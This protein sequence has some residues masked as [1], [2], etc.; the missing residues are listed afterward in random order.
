VINMSLGSDYGGPA[1]DPDIVA[2]NNAAEAGVIVVIAAGN[3]GDNVYIHGSPGT[4]LKGIG[5][6]GVT[7]P[8]NDLFGMA[9]FTPT[10]STHE[11]MPADWGS[12]FVKNPVTATVAYVGRGCGGID[13]DGAVDP[14]L[15]DPVTDMI[16]LIDRGTCWFSDKAITAEDHGAAGVLIKTYAGRELSG[17]SPGLPTHTVDIPVVMIL[18]DLGEAMK[19]LLPTQTITVAL[20]GDYIIA[21]LGDTVYASSSRG[22]RYIDSA[23]KPDVAAPSVNVM[24]AQVGTGD[25]GI[26]YSGTS[27][28]TPHVAG[29]AALLR[30][31]F[32]DWN[33]WEIKAALMNTAVD[34]AD[35]DG[36]KY[37]LSRQGAGR[38]AVYEAGQ[39][40]SVALGD[41][42]P[43]LA[44]GIPVTRYTSSLSWGVLP[45]S[46]DGVWYKTVEVRNKRTGASAAISRTYDVTWTFQFTTD[47]D[48]GVS[49]VVPEDIAVLPGTAEVFTV[50]LH[51]DAD[52]LPDYV[53]GT[54]ALNEFDGF[55]IVSETFQYGDSGWSRDYLRVPFHLIP[56]EYSV[57]EMGDLSNDISYT[58]AASATVTVSNTGLITADNYFVTAIFTDANNSLV[59]DYGD[60]RYV[61]LESWGSGLSF[62]INTYGLMRTPIP[63]WGEF[64]I[65]I[66]VDEDGASD[67]IVYN[68]NYGRLTG[69]GFDNQWLP[70]IIDL[71]TGGASVAYLSYVDF[72]SA[73]M[74]MLVPASYIGLGAGNTDFDF[75][76]VYYDYNGNYGVTSAGSYNIAGDPFSFSGGDDPGPSNAEDLT[77]AINPTGYLANPARKGVMALYYND[78][79][80]MD[81]AEIMMFAAEHL[82]FM[83]V[84]LKNAP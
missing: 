81:Q 25:D 10:Q 35:L 12:D 15:T 34:M 22:P 49:L 26:S 75:S 65:Y 6:A 69:Q 17:M 4:A 58:G 48:S 78:W 59:A 13:P 54:L 16:V 36:N 47:Y 72:N 27:M 30:G 3:A 73:L 74:E 53:Y 55:V 1:G 50:E 70:V 76:V 32:P 79:I 45:V 64:D 83:P 82:C 57:D 46:G 56:R 2:S 60:I 84:I 77:V 80:G 38:I 63:Y 24:S 11:V 18:H 7:D 66:D 28:G 8:G 44:A 41:G 23:L 19:T 31:L 52:A 71:S 40:S 67:Y 51:I 39:L 37:P 21:N 14:Y 9:V 29:A 33:P 61:G 62:V 20:S 43:P 5:V 68:D 42:D